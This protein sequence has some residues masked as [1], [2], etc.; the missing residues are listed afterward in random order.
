[1]PVPE[2][3]EYWMEAVSIALPELSQ[4]QARVLG[5]YSYGMAMTKQSGQ[6]IVSVFLALLLG[7]KSQN[8]RQRL[9]EC[10]YEAEQKR[11]RKR[12][13]VVVAAQFAPLLRWVLAQWVRGEQVVLG[14]DV[15]YL[16]DR[17]TVLCISVLYSQT[18]IPVAW[19]VLPGNT[20][21]EWHPHWLQLLAAIAPALPARYQV[22]VLLDRGLYSKRLFEAMRGYGWHPFMRLRTQGCYQRQGHRRWHDLKTVAYRGMTATAWRVRCFKGDPLV[23][24]LWVAWDRRYPEPCLL[25]SDLAPRQLKGNPYPLR[26]WIEAGFKDFKRG[27][28]HW[29]QSKI[30]A[31][32]R[33]ER[34]L[35]VMT[36]AL[37]HLLRLGGIPG[38]ATRPLA[39]DPLRRLSRITLGWLRLLVSTIQNLPLSDDFF[40]PYR[41]PPYLPEKTYP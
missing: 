27:G 5:W 34:L 18:A 8:V 29:E 1:M 11:G 25:L 40:L 12:C 7:L 3:L 21:G 9:K 20:K 17:Y 2:E 6:T 15:T 10:L 28:L 38:D 35:L 41:F 4:S 30:P 14:V 39:S 23:G 13:E 32:E 19:K 33:M 16:K 24:V 36:L 37:F 22:L 26:M 31:A